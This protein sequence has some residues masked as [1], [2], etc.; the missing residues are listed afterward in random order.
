MTTGKK[1]S[2][3]V[4]SAAVRWFLANRASPDSDKGLFF[5][6]L[7]REP[8]A[9]DV[10]DAIEETWRALGALAGDRDLEREL[11]K[12][13][14]VHRWNPTAVRYGAGLTLSG[15]VIAALLW[16]SQPQPTRL[17]TAIG[18]RA[19]IELS[20]GSILTLNTQ[21]GVSVRLGKTRR[22]VALERGEV[23]FNVSH[24]ANA[25]FLVRIHDA[26]LRV[27]GT[28]FDVEKLPK[29][30]RVEVT[31]GRIAVMSGSPAAPEKVF[32][33][34]GEGVMLDSSGFV[35]GHF[36]ADARRIQNW[37]AGRLELS[38]TTLRD[39]V[40]ELNRHSSLQIQ[41]LS[42]E[43][44]TRRISGIFELGESEAFAQSLETMRYADIQRKPD[45]IELRAPR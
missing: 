33:D 35:R 25:P 26:T 14:A 4:T 16:M 3:L 42:P 36:A 38:N 29:G 9:I 39:A 37:R 30:A 20:D 28:Q 6:W 31:Q 21:S 2:F 13:V 1:G 23:Y 44:Q 45:V 34:A 5:R 18:E 22:E 19:P 10:Y 40:A 43:I 11:G 12:P 41:I 27:I 32:V 17:V 7:R 24:N 8:T 15:A